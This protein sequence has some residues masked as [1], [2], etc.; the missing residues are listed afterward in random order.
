MTSDPAGFSAQWLA[1][2]EPFD[3]AAREAGAP[4]LGLPE[5]IARWRRAGAGSRAGGVLG[6]LDLG[7]GHGANLRALAPRLGGLQRWRLV[8]HDPGLLAAVPEALARWSRQQGYHFTQPGDASDAGP[9]CIT[10]PSF[11][12]EVLRQRIDLARDLSSLDLAQPALI[13]ASALLDLV[14]AAWLQRLIQ[15]ARDAGAAMLLALTVDGRSAWQPADPDDEAVH[16]LFSRHQRRDKGFGPALG[17][18]APAVALQQMANAGYQTTMAR[19]D[20]LI[21][22]AQAAAL[23]RAMIEGIA[24]AARE[25]DPTAHDLV[26]A[27]QSRREA[28]VGTSS[29][30]V[31]HVDI[32]ASLP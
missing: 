23:Q 6:V 3:H 22:G 25:Q 11:C 20:W 5:H 9:C 8:D 19:T 29:L 28:C 17:P 21:A 24:A 1:L 4:Q 10:G 2:R 18:Q 14:S 32:V 13:T 26:T 7:C 31:G 16:A 30:R 27:W 15:R 12:A